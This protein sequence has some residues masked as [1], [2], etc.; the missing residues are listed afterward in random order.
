MAEDDEY[1]YHAAGIDGCDDA[2][3]LIVL[4][5]KSLMELIRVRYKEAAHGDRFGM[6]TRAGPVVVAMNPFCDVKD[7]LYTPAVLDDYKRSAERGA[8]TCGR[9]KVGIRVESG[10]S[11]AGL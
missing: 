6:Y 5:D 7:A 3:E 4:S 2:A 1:D 11:G 10:G 8:R 9:S